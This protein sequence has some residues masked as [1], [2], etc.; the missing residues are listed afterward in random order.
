MQKKEALDGVIAHEIGHNWFMAML[1]SNERLHTWMDEGLNTYFQFRYEAEKY[2]FNSIF[3]DA[4]PAD[5]KKLPPDK[6]LEIIYDAMNKSLPMQAAMETPADKF[7][8]SDEYGLVSYIKT[9]LWL[10]MLE[11]S[12]GRD[13]V[14]A[15]IHNYFNK[16]KFKHPEPEDMQ[17]AFEEAIGA[18]LAKFFQLTKK[19][20]AFE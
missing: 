9:A 12:V 16:W 13:K 11:A 6:F 20:G 3:G 7:P 2:N 14:D 15:A 10:Y 4:I 18:S 5:L 19:E 1:G 17:A 8:N